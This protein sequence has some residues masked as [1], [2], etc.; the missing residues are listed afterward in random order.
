[1]HSI[2]K[3]YFISGATLTPDQGQILLAVSEMECGHCK[4]VVEKTLN[5]M[6]GVQVVNVDLANGQALV[7]APESLLPQILSE[8][9]QAGH[10]A[11]KI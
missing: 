1:L 9:E 7:K 4:Q 6:Q 5:S 2:L 11:S 3:K 10:K 8:L